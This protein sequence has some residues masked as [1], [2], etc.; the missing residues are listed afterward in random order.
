[1][2]AQRWSPAE[3]QAWYAAQPWLVGC[4]FIPSNAIN[5]LE[6]WQA[7]TFDPQT[8]ERELGWGAGLG[9][10]AV[11]VFLHDLLWQQ[12]AAG[13]KERMHRYLDIADGHGIK[14]MFVFFDDCWN[15]NPRLGP[16]PE[17]RPGVHGS[18]WAKSPGTAVLADPGAWSRLEDYVSDIVS[19][20]GADERVVVWDIYNEPGNHFL[21]TLGLPKA[22]SYARLLPQLARY[23]L[24][25][26]PSAPLLEQA[27]GWARAAAP[28][29][30]LTTA[31]WYLRAGWG[32]K[33]NERALA[34]SDV[35][36]FHSYFDLA[37]T[38]AI[39]AGL[40]AAQRPVFCTEYLSRHS[41]SRFETHL[42]FFK[43]QKVS[44]YNWGLVSG[45]TNTIYGWESPPGAP[46]PEVWFHDILRPD[47]RPFSAEEVALIRRVTAAEQ[48]AA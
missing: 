6:M 25:P 38:Q 23:L 14:T 27:F 11:R 36:S 40:Q 4:N 15:D 13:F 19:T 33:L 29:Q 42:P 8:L 2:N 45:K 17:P 20:F 44:C 12:D 5:Q 35:I 21:L 32:S 39:V 24:R 26:S 46:E 30:P 10:N 3:A 7:D 28:R 16:Q 37:T 31:L 9:F 41:G 18:G 48:A 1:M 47:G 22:L 34:L 43:E